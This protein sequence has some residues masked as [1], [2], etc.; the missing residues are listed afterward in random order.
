MSC[1][2]TESNRKTF[3]VDTWELVLQITPGQTQIVHPSTL[4]LGSRDDLHTVSLLWPKGAEPWPSSEGHPQLQPL[5]TD[6]SLHPLT[7]VWALP[8]TVVWNL[9]GS[10]RRSRCILQCVLFLSYLES[11]E[12]T[13]LT[14]ARSL[15][16]LLF[17]GWQ[18]D[19]W[20]N[21]ARY[22]RAW[23]HLTKTGIVYAEQQC[24]NS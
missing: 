15:Q 22:C 12:Q 9:V 20:S 23:P 4:T 19:Y 14:P 24:G 2:F 13:G 11:A 8:S 16:L 17:L 1:S 21:K 3:K 18:A 6:P 10:C 5:D 7:E